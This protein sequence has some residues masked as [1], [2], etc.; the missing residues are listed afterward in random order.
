MMYLKFDTLESAEKILTSEG[1][2]LNEYKD[3]FAGK[4]GFGTIFR[5]PFPVIYKGDEVIETFEDGVF[6]NVYECDFIKELSEYAVP[7]PKT[8]YNVLS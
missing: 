1:F 8:P 5:I 6:V 7:S 2:L 3:S 4:K